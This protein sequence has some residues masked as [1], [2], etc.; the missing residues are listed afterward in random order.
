MPK[1]TLNLGL[2]GQTK[3]VEVEL[4]ANEAKPWDADAKLK[5]VGKA[6]PRIDGTPKVSGQAKYTFDIV[7]EGMLYAAVARCP[8]PAATIKKIDLSRAAAM[9]GVKAVHAVAKVGERMLFAGQDVAAVA[10]TRPELARDAARA[11]LV[12]YKAEHFVTEANAAAKP[13]APPVHQGVIKERRTGGDAPGAGGAAKIVGNLRAGRP[14]ARGDVSAGKRR[15][16][17]HS[18]T[19][20]TQVQTHA[21]LETHGLVVR[22]EDPKHMTVWCSTQSIFSVRDEMAQIFG[23]SAG[24]VRVVAEFVGGG[25]GAKFGASAPGSRIGTIAGELARKAGAAVKL[26]CTR[27]EEHVCTGNRP[28]AHQQLTIAANKRGDL[29]AIEVTSIGTA[30]IGTGAGVGRN[31]FAIYTKCPNVAVNAS[32]VFTNAG[33]GTAM[34]APGHPQGA[35]ALELGLDE[36]AA[37]LGLDPLE[38]RIRHDE[39]PVRLHQFKT[40]AERFGWQEKRARSADQRTRGTRIRRGVGVAASIWGDFGRANATSATC[41]IGRDGSIEVHNGVQDIGVGITTVLAQIAAEVFHRPLEVIKVRMGNSTLGSSV[42][43]GGSQTTSSVTPAVRNACETAK[44]QLTELAAKLLGAKPE[45]V[46]WDGDGTA[47]AGSNSLSFLQVCKKIDGEAI[48]AV[49]T[50]PE[51]YGSEPMRFMG[52]PIYQIGGVQFAEVEVDTW[53]GVV[54]AKRVLALHDCGRP[55][56]RLT[57]RSQINGGVILGTSYGLMEQRVMDHDLGRMLNANLETYKICGAKDTPDIE[58][59][60]TEVYTGGNNTGAVG[61]G[62]PSTIP[63]AAAL[64]CAVFDA[65]GTPVRELP[66]T[67]AAVL[68]ALAAAE[69]RT[70]Q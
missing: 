5:V 10:A 42:G 40:G 56:N 13:G 27:H 60:L 43:S 33:P 34:R 19:Y 16:V 48:T 46:R 39:H 61:I 17:V 52:A 11:I 68:T 31:A 14:M 29:K 55:M 67:P 53:T 49:R 30:G 38:L 44:I 51:T 12:E 47:I 57:L 9:P 6:I 26:M 3:K 23:L 1:Q 24:D 7:V 69:Q 37:K 20:R 18:A 35:F 63:T 54:Q 15:A 41:Q 65:L 32:D 36:L 25:F 58:I 4:P 70:A 2:E 8:L 62:E 45:Q 66:M 21:A 50:R 64:A 59:V 22:W 28:D